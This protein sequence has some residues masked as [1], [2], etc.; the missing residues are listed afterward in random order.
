MTEATEGDPLETLWRLMPPTADSDTQADWTQLGESW[1]MAFPSDY[2][3]LIETYGAGEVQNY[4]SI[5]SPEPRK[6]KPS[7]D[8]M[9]AETVNAEAAWAREPKAPELDGAHPELIAWGVDASAD[10]VCW[11]ASGDDPDKWPVLAW[12]RDERLWSRYECGVA[13]FIVRV[14]RADFPGCPLSDLSLWGR[15][16]A[17]YLN[18]REY[19]RLLRQGLDPWTGEPDPYAGMFGDWNSGE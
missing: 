5:L 3:W 19:M 16:T 4:L 12:S 1:G 14:L 15:R 6:T 8:G 7:R 13:E 10:I 9:I 18:K 17:K 11:D 2:R